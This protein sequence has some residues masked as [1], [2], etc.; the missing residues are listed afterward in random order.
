MCDN[1]EARRRFVVN[2]TCMDDYTFI[3]IS[4]EFVATVVGY[5]DC[6]CVVSCVC[7][8]CCVCIVGA[9]IMIAETIW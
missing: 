6:A 2:E 3:M 1:Y 5:I 4:F 8:T 9:D 7:C